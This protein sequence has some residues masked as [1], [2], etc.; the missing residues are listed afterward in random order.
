ML[1]YGF[2]HTH[3]LMK[4]AISM[5][6]YVLNNDGQPSANANLKGLNKSKDYSTSEVRI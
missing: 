6:V 1:A 5:V 3:N 2:K 4:G